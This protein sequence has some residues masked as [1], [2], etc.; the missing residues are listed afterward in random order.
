MSVSNPSAPAAPHPLSAGYVSY[1]MWMLLIIYTLNF[2]D[3][4]IV[5]IL[6]EPIKRDLDLSDTQLGLLTGLAFAVVYTV[7]GIP[8]ARYADQFKSNRVG[9]ISIALAVWSAFTVL[10]GLA[11]NFWQLLL[12]R[13]GVGVGEAG[14]TPPA[15]SLITDKVPQD[16]RASALA[17]YSMGVPLGTLLGF[18]FGGWIAEH[19]GWRAAFVLVGAPGVLLALA[20][21]LTIKEPRKLGLVKPPAS[22]APKVNFGQALKQL[23]GVK[24]YWYACF[25][26]SILAFMGYGQN[27]FLGSFYARVHEMPI[28]Q[29]GVNLGIVLGVAGML[30][31]WLGGQI[32][33]R[34]AK[35]DTRAYFSVPAIALI[36][37]APFF[38][39]AFMAEDPMM[40]LVLLAIPT[41]LNS[42]WFGP[43]YA[44]VQ[45][46][47]PASL[48]ATAVAIM[49][50][51]INMV[52]LGLGPTALGMLSDFFGQ[53]QGMGAAEGLRWAIISSG[54]VGLAA[55]VL[56]WI[57]RD[58][59]REDLERARNASV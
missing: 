39:W 1:A 33:D 3:R 35:K 42:L 16:K 11:Q 12:A 44:T 4:Q 32:A 48:R 38:V 18:A 26:A 36:V 56:F 7:L 52:G 20:A 54:A 49:F 37:G 50:F 43:V 2:L 58:T 17:F 14:C 6:A 46:V 25:A 55:V 9:I 57:A 10:C 30:G 21:W 47:V 24:S 23:A 27:A 34:A 5:N 53:G 19:L 22:D 40:S 31:T 13:I 41:L 15:H 8:I 45:S 28:S 59:I 51:I 29:I